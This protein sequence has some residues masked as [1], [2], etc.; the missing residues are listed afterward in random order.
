MDVVEDKAHRSP[1]SRSPRSDAPSS[2][3][4]VFL[5]PFIEMIYECHGSVIKV[6]NFVYDI[7]LEFFSIYIISYSLVL[8]N[9]TLCPLLSC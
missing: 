2:S 9:Y 4:A 7:I 5:S 3:R 1:N 8:Y 6:Y